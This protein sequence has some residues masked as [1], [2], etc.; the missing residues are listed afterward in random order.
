M[1]A[2]QQNHPDIIQLGDVSKI[3]P[4]PDYDMVLAGSPCQGF[5]QAG[6]KLGFEDPRSKLFFEFLRIL[7][8]VKPKYFLLEN[9]VL[10]PAWRDIITAHLDVESIL[11]N[12]SCVSAQNR[13]RL[14]WTNIPF[15][16]SF[17]KN[18]GP[19]LYD[20]VG[21]SQVHVYPRGNNPGG[22]RDRD[23][24]NCITSSSWESNIRLAYKNYRGGTP[25]KDK[26]NCLI[27]SKWNEKV[28]LQIGTTVRQF[29]PEEGEQFQTVTPGYTHGLSKTRRFKLLGNCWTVD[30]IANIFWGLHNSEQLK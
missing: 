10:K 13:P 3:T 9:V 28:N 26:V 19:T 27:T 29:T 8:A 16:P 24:V 21:S 11:I 2:S 6:N 18:P 30:V 23:K 25:G 22:L 1:Q 5:S 12:S 17:T 15:D 4:N 7:N 20:V 14:Y